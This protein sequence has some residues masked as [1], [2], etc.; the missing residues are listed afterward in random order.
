[1]TGQLTLEPLTV[2]VLPHDVALLDELFDQE[3][4]DKGYQA[5]RSTYAGDLLSQAI[6]RRMR[7]VNGG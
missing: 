3:R 5:S 6:H 1:V 4:R 7:E 2:Y